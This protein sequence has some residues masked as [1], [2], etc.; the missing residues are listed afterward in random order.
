MTLRAYQLSFAALLLLGATSLAQSASDVVLAYNRANEFKA[1]LNYVEA[2]K[3]YKRGLELALLVHGEEH[4]NTALLLNAHG[5]LYDRQ[6]KFDEAEKIYARNLKIVEKLSGAEDLNVAIAL[7]SLGNVTVE[8]GKFETADKLLKRALEIREKSKGEGEDTTEVGDSLND[9][10]ILASKQGKNEEAERLYRRSLIIRQKTEGSESLVVAQS[11]SNLG[12]T[13]HELDRHKDAEDSHRRALEIREKVNGPDHPTTA[14]SLNNLGILLRDVGRYQDAEQAHR[15]AL[16]IREV[17]LS[18][19]SVRTIS[20]ASNLAVVCADQGKFAEAAG[21]FMRALASYER[22]YGVDHPT[23]SDTLGSLGLLERARGRNAEAERYLLRS[24]AVAEKV[25]G[26][27]SQSIVPKINNLA[28]LQTERSKFAEAEVLYRRSLAIHEKAVGSDH[29]AVSASLTDLANLAVER[30][31][32]TDAQTLLERS[33]KI[34]EKAYGSE[35]PAV[36]DAVNSLAVVANKA[37]DRKAAEAFYRRNV[38]LMEKLFGTGHLAY[39]E[40]VFSL[41][42]FHA[43]AGQHVEAEAGYQQVLTIFEKHLGALHP[44]VANTQML[45]GTTLRNQGKLAA[46]REMHQRARAM[47]QKIFGLDHPTVNANISHLATDA[48]M[49]GKTKDAAGLFDEHRRSARRFLMRDLPY[50]P[51]AE[52][53]EFIVQSEVETFAKALTLGRDRATESGMARRSAEWLLNGKNAALE[54]RTLRARLERDLTDPEARQAL[55]EVQDLRSREAVLLVQEGGPATMNARKQRAEM[56]FR[57]RI[58]E[59]T[60][61]GPSAT[62]F[63]P[64]V[65]LDEVRS[66]MPAGSLFVDIARFHPARISG[67]PGEPAWDTTHYVAWVIPPTGPITVVDLGEAAPIDAAIQNARLEIADGVRVAQQL[68]EA[69]AEKKLREVLTKLAD[70]V[71]KPFASQLQGVK[72]LI[73]SPDGDLWLVPWAALPIDGDRYLVEAMTPR[74]VHSGRDLLKPETYKGET[75]APLVVADPS[76]DAAPVAGLPRLAGTE[77]KGRLGSFDATFVFGLAGKLSVRIP[78][79]NLIGQGTWKQAG[80]LV[81]METERSVYTSK[82]VG[83]E[84]KGERRLKEKND[85]L[86]DGFVLELETSETRPVAAA[87]TRAGPLSASRKHG[88]TAAALLKELTTVE[89]RL[90]IEAGATEQAVKAATRPKLLVLATHSFHLPASSPKGD[91]PLVRSGL[92]L[93]GSNRG[94]EAREGQEDGVLSAAEIVGLDLRG[95]RMVVLSGSD[96]TKAGDAV[97]GLR[98]A[99]RMAGTASVLSTLWPSI[100]AESTRLLNRFYSRLALEESASLALADMQREAI[101]ARRKANGA[102]HPYSWAAFTMTG[103]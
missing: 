25:Y 27:V 76:F 20:S 14:D 89:A 100:D 56:R 81:I 11:L 78:E 33:L 16:N 35:H 84:L 34:R 64:W 95:T 18:A 54:S 13:L 52:Q 69:Q 39:A 58:L 46:A 44:N 15:R 92:Y 10:A 38:V 75:S 4:K 5:E 79:G 3:E 86:P 68:G 90:L 31:Q 103:R 97:A 88:E 43:S 65:D 28:A 67:R 87:A 7:S 53:R 48:W 99:F 12:L 102:A 63:P 60:L 21:W 41:A 49:D 2:D 80:D 47:S 98:Q 94:A 71:L 45:L 40:T 8:L 9:L 24:L 51:E 50:L 85:V 37:G 93:A 62:L 66:A 72:N 61:G 22:V 19:D 29:P 57:R 96:A 55:S 36:H 82:I 77:A 59:Q 70:R 23:V 32:P 17:A 91:D 74:L 1:A 101:L 6:N 42:G 26:P 30:G 83:R 73:L